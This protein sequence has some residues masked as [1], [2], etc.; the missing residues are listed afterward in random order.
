[1]NYQD[2]TD[3]ELT[4]LTIKALKW[5]RILHQGEPVQYV[6]TDGVMVCA[7]DTDIFNAQFIQD[8]LWPMLREKG[9]MVE[10]VYFFDDHLFT[11]DLYERI[12]PKR[13]EHS[14]TR[15]FINVLSNEKGEENR[16]CIIAWLKA[17]DKLE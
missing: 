10:T 8:Y 15:V 7:F 14:F 17:M 13:G 11:V 16:T 12:F 3:E 9:L 1:M 4:R 5:R 6:R 2:K